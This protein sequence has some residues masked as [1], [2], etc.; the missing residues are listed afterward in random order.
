[1]DNNLL[2]H[3]ISITISALAVLVA[4]LSLRDA[5]SKSQTE[6]VARA[7]RELQ[8]KAQDC[9]VN[10]KVLEERLNNTISLLGR[11]DKTLDEIND[12]LDNRD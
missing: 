7:I 1:M 12:E 3:I 4:F 6:D 10:Y 8:A 5:R 2:F 11:V 9:D